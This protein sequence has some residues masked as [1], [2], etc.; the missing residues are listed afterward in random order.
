MFLK[1]LAHLP[2]TDSTIFE[3]IISNYQCKCDD[4]TCY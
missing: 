4:Y 3:I 2:I 1:E